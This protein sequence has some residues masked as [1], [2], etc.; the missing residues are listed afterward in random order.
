MLLNT[1]CNT[2]KRDTHRGSQ[3][4]TTDTITSDIVACVNRA[5]RD[6]QRLLPKR[7][8]LKQSTLALTA[9]T[10]GTP[11]VYSLASDVQDI[12]MLTYFISSTYYIITKIDSDREWL[13]QI[14]NPVASTN[15]PYYFREIGPDS[16]GYKQIEIFPIPNASITVNIE[17]YRLKTA[18]LSVSDLLSQLPDIPDQ[19]QDVVEK[20]AIY[21]FL[22]GFDDPLG[23]VAKEDYSEAIMALEVGDERNNAGDLRLRMGTMRYEIPGFRLE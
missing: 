13:Q 18:D 17:Y 14:W 2:V 8:W 23:G 21:Y 20:G 6:I 11:A 12:S 5:I 4:V 16:S 1:I 3:L 15:R 9:G 7:F 10:A 22:K 19:Y